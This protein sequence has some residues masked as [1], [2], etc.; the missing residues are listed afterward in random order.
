[1][2]EIPVTPSGISFDF[3]RSRKGVV[4]MIDMEQEVKM[5][6]NVANKDWYESKGYTYTKF[7]DTFKVKVNDLPTNSKVKVE[8]TCDFCGET[9]MKSYVNYNKSIEKHSNGI[10]G[11]SCS[12]CRGA[13]ISSATKL[14]FEVVKA[15]FEKYGL[16]LQD[17]IYT[18]ADSPMPCIC[19]KHRDKGIQY[20]AYGELKG[21]KYP[22]VF[23]HREARNINE[24]VLEI[25]PEMEESLLTKHVNVRWSNQNR[26]HYQS[27]GYVFTK[28]GDIFTVRTIDLTNG[29]PI[30]VNCKCAKCGSV[31]S[32]E[33]RKFIKNVKHGGFYKCSNCYKYTQEEIEKL[34]DDAGYKVLSEFKGTDKSIWY[35]CPEHGKQRIIVSNFISG[36]R[37]KKCSDESKLVSYDIVKKA[38]EDRGYTLLS[39]KYKGNKQLLKYTCWC[40]PTV[41]HK[42]K[43]NDIQQGHGCPTCKARDTS[44][45][46]KGEGSHF[47]NGGISDLSGY[48]RNCIG[49][50]K[51]DSM[52][53]CGFKCVL[54]G[55][56]FD[57]VHHLTSFS[58]IMHEMLEEINMDIRERVSM[59]T[60]EELEIMSNRIVTKHNDY[61]LGICLCDRL[62]KLFH[63]LYGK[64]TVTPEDFQEFKQRY[65]AG[66][67][68]E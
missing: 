26:L 63:K 4:K 42:I 21:R 62:H 17:S 10:V 48:L 53:A 58:Y 15:E 28:N 33:Y 66:E 36:N 43:Y 27:L 32:I 44:E 6:W 65:E 47:W 40:D 60:E 9:V 1:V 56:K 64:V 38:F 23:C 46:Q 50:W 31:T 39:E 59:Y 37:C 30:V 35:K 55:E 41:V 51:Y 57:A 54:T 29:S 7:R 34:F 13:K 67:F 61:G 68:D 52:K 11:D 22:C 49:G 2:L 12:N 3:L 20:V 18:T 16:E 45:R 19:N 25:T 14:P 8:V 24:D 5:S